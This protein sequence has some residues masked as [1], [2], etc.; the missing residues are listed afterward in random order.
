MAIELKNYLANSWTH[1]KEEN[2]KIKLTVLAAGL[3][4]RMDPRINTT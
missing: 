4:K 1:K 3:G 2:G